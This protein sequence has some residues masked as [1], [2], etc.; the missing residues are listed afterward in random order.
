MSKLFK[1]RDV[2]PFASQMCQAP[3]LDPHRQFVGDTFPLNA[4]IRGTHGDYASTPHQRVF[5]VPPPDL[6]CRGQTLLL[7]LDDATQGT[8]DDTL[9]VRTFASVRCAVCAAKVAMKS[10]NL[11]FWRPT[12]QYWALPKP[13]KIRWAH[14]LRVRGEERL[15]GISNLSP[16]MS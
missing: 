5:T 1:S 15:S 8:S 3:S 9:H 7:D 6:T 13:H 12:P 11:L 14:R 10:R 2:P 4:L 16:L